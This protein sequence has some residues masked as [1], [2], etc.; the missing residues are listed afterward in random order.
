MRHGNIQSFR[1][2]KEHL[3]RHCNTLIEINEYHIAFTYRNKAGKWF[4]KKLHAD[5]V[6]WYLKEQYNEN[7]SKPKKGSAG[8]RGGRPILQGLTPETKH[9][10]RILLIYVNTRDVKRV[11]VAYA[12][13]K[14]LKKRYKQMVAHIDELEEIGVP[15]PQPLKRLEETLRDNDEE[16]LNELAPLNWTERIEVL[17]RYSLD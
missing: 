2:K 5:C 15:Y 1:G 9:R 16:L 8:V 13:G 14:N 6:Q 11:I 10:R 17:R 3:C 12:T 7:A 4:S